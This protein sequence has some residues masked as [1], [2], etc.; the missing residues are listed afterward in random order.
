[1]LVL[2][3]RE[4]ESDQQRDRDDS[5]CESYNAGCTIA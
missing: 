3:A 4:R 1:M 5:G 2:P